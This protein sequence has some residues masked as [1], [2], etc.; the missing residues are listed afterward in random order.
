[1]HHLIFLIMSSYSFRQLQNVQLLMVI[2][3]V[4][5]SKPYYLAQSVYPL[6]D[7]NVRNWRCSKILLTLICR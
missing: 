2:C 6:F 1:M 5:T 4:V 7:M 3:G